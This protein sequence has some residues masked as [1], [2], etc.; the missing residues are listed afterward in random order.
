ML[1][2][3]GLGSLLGNLILAALGDFRRKAR[4]LMASILVQSVVLTL[5]AWSPWQRIDVA[6]L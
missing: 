2:A 6:I 5:F 4:L 3:V 1:L